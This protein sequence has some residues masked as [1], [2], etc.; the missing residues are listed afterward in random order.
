[1]KS[2]LA[3]LAAMLALATLATDAPAAPDKGINAQV[4]HCVPRV[5]SRRQCINGKM[6]TCEYRVLRNCRVTGRRCLVPHV[7]IPCSPSKQ[8]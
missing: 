3:G 4:R 1:M 6:V 7:I 8:Y 2:F 5:V